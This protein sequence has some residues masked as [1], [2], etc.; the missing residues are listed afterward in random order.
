MLSADG[1]D[2][3]VKLL[4]G[5]LKNEFIQ[6]PQ[7]LY[8]C[9]TGMLNVLPSPCNDFFSYIY[10]QNA[11]SVIIISPPHL[12]QKQNKTKRKLKRKMDCF[13]AL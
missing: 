2:P 6:S 12:P 8:P 7:H 5:R 4:S 10:S 9:N 1:V 11:C 3:P 13:Y